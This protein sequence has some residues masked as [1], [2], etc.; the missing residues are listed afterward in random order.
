MLM[1]GS[2]IEKKKKRRTGWI[3]LA[4]FLMIL[5]VSAYIGYGKY[6]ELKDRAYSAKHSAEEAVSLLKDGR[7]EEAQVKTDEVRES[8]KY[9][10]AL[11]EEEHIYNIGCRLPKYGEDF[12]TACELLDLADRTMDK[13]SDRAFGL[14]REYPLSDLVTED[15]CDIKGALAYL[16]FACEAVPEAEET[17]KVLSSVKLSFIDIP[18][19]IDEHSEKINELLGYYHQAE[20]YVPLVKAVLGDG[21]DKTFLIAA[22]NSAEM[23]PCGGFPGSMGTVEIRDGK[24]NIGEFRSVW[25]VYPSDTPAHIMPSQS[26]NHLFGGL[27]IWPRD[28]EFCPDFEYLGEFWSK[29]YEY[30]YGKPL[31]GIVSLTPAVIQDVLGVLGSVE[32]SN[33]DVLDGS[34]AVKL[35]QHDWYVKYMNAYSIRNGIDTPDETM[36]RLFEDT[37]KGTVELVKEDLDPEKV[38]DLVEVMEDAA[39]D[40]TFML[41]LKDEEAE[42]LVK[43]YGFGGELGEDPEDPEVGVFYGND[44]GMKLGWWIDAEVSVG[45]GRQLADGRMEYDVTV[46]FRNNFDH[47]DTYSMGSY[48]VGKWGNAVLDWYAYVFAPA[49]GSVYDMYI[50]YWNPGEYS[51]FEG[52]KVAYKHKFYINPGTESTLRC[53]I[54]TAPGVTAKPRVVQT[55]TL[56]EYR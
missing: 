49:G 7:F 4:V 2:N 46:V 15:G 31:D 27:M 26:V 41:W 19:Y 52:L 11:A 34:N 29:M 54:C 55:P 53:K 24:L 8:I 10:R 47:A 22:Q 37:V 9:F 56:T 30:E 5:S 20:E 12:R 42:D 39:E 38:M 36:N 16:D 23:R 14:L 45:D 43:S 48:I 51:S 40:R 6:T 28:A 3:V 21:E 50:D 33:G 44:Y 32:V 35:L 25:D 18:A 1:N 13:W 17:L